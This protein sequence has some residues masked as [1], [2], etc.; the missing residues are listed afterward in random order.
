MSIA[1]L[2]DFGLTE[3]EAKVYLANM[4]LGTA[5]IQQISRKANIKRT[6]VYAVAESLKKQGILSATKKG[7]KTLLVAETPDNLV[8]LAQKRWQ[9]L[10]N[11]LPELKSIYNIAGAKP[12]LR[13][14]EGKEGYLAV[15]EAVLK[16]KPKE[17]L[18]VASYEHFLKHIDQTYE[19]DWTK[20]R[21]KLGIKLRWLDFKTK[22][23]EKLAKEGKKALREVR[24]LPK[25]FAFTNTMFIYNDKMVVVSGKAKEFIAVVIENPEFTQMFKQ[26]FEMLWLA[27]K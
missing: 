5:T 12:T 11:S 16:G 25:R 1:S 6:T 24:F 10:K 26:F 3:N 14:Y 22:T 18:A 13:F 9:S 15:Y 2:K 19:E 4:E 27:N 21:I 17:F 7:S 20:K 23:T 8:R